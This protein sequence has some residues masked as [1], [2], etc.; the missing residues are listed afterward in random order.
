[1]CFTCARVTAGVGKGRVRGPGDGSAQRLRVTA[2][3]A[4]HNLKDRERSGDV[5]HSHE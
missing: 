3:F 5:D 1:M 2:T 4:G